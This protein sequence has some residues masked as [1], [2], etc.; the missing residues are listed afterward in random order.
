MFYA[1]SRQVHSVNRN[2][3]QKQKKYFWCAERGRCLGLTT[4][5]PYES[6]LSRQCGI[7]NISQPYRPPRPVTGI[8]L[9]LLLLYSLDPKPRDACTAWDVPASTVTREECS[10]ARAVNSPSGAL[11][12]SSACQISAL[13]RLLGHPFRY[14]TCETRPR[15]YILSSLF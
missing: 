5:P 8:A 6:R 7:L 3:Y 1:D 15:N 13:A 4:L 11:V 9:I 12:C 2:K 10:Q 14:K